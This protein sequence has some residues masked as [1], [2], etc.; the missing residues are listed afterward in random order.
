MGSQLYKP[1]Q[2]EGTPLFKRNC[3]EMPSKWSSN[4]SFN[5]SRHFSPLMN[6]EM[7]SK[8]PLQPGFDS[9]LAV[10]CFNLFFSLKNRKAS[11]AND[12]HRPLQRMTSYKGLVR[13]SRSISIYA[14]T[15]IRSRMCTP[16]C[17]S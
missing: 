2:I 14:D 15:K 3:T 4:V 1:Q 9:F 13:R 5:I 11:S 10:E 16:W 8:V 6:N 12:Y 7:K 17:R